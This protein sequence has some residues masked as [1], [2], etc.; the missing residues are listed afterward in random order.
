MTGDP[1]FCEHDDYLVVTAAGPFERRCR[2][3]P[4]VTV[5]VPGMGEPAPLPPY[6]QRGVVIDTSASPE[7]P[8]PPDVWARWTALPGD[9]R[10]SALAQHGLHPPGH[11]ARQPWR[12]PGQWARARWR[13]HRTV[14]AVCR[15]LLGRA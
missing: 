14:L 11:A 2:H 10:E 9:V 6:L 5:V 7:T 4:A 15:R 8:A 3:C 12:H 13:R 1:V